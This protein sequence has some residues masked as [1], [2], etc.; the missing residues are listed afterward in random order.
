MCHNVWIWSSK[1]TAFSTS[2]EATALSHSPTT[3]S[4]SPFCQVSKNLNCDEHLLFVFSSINNCDYSCRLWNPVRTQ[5]LH[6]STFLSAFLFFIP[7]AEWNF[8]SL[9]ILRC[10]Q[11]WPQFCEVDW[12]HVALHSKTKQNKKSAK[13]KMRVKKQLTSFSFVFQKSHFLFHCS[14]CFPS[15]PKMFFLSFFFL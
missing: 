8:N 9:P 14:V 2:S 6:L 7:R 3:S 13:W 15:F 12:L 1:R 4:F 10:G 11:C 5:T